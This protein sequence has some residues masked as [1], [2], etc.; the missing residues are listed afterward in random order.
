MLARLRMALAFCGI[1][2]AEPELVVRVSLDE[3]GLDPAAL[4]LLA[5]QFGLQAEA[6]Q[7]DLNT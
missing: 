5:N 6:R 1:E 2:V 3:G 7:L 4:A